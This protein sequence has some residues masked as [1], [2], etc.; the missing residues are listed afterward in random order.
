LELTDPD[1]ITP[2]HRAV[3]LGQHGGDRR[4]QK[5]QGCNATLKRG[6]AAHWIARL[7]RDGHAELAAKVRTG[8]LSANAAAIAAGFRKVRTPLE[9]ISRLL[10]KLTTEE[11][12]LL[13]DELSRLE[14][15]R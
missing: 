7:D 14:A 12:H 1:S 15:G 4:S 11:R 8:M 2:F 13:L 6:T 9:Q 3:A 10:P 5:D